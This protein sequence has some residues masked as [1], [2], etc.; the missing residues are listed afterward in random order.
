MS[1]FREPHYQHGVIFCSTPVR[2]YEF[3]TAIP[4]KTRE[5]LPASKLC[6]MPKR[7]GFTAF[8]EKCSEGERRGPR[9]YRIEASRRCERD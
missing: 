9:R 3:R 7:F 4:L 2:C 5:V 8:S 1:Y 6:F